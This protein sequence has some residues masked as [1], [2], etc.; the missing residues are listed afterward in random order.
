MI[1]LCVKVRSNRLPEPVRKGV[2]LHEVIEIWQQLP[3]ADNHET[4]LL[5]EELLSLEV[6]E[7]VNDRIS[8]L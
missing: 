6:Q 4:I 8:E 7:L 5:E 2:M 3:M 1:N